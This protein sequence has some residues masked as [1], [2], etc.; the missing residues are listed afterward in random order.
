MYFRINSINMLK[1]YYIYIYNMTT[2]FSLWNDTAIAHIF[3]RL[4][5]KTNHPYN[6]TTL[7]LQ[8]FNNDYTTIKS[9]IEWKNNNNNN[10]FSLY[11][12]TPTNMTELI[13]LINYDT[14]NKEEL[15]KIWRTT[16]LNL[17]N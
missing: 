2:P 15:L 16:I 6:T 4:I 7:T 5:N 3:M 9:Y 8:E 12:F 11:N 10:K 14:S 1:E 17:P 13:N